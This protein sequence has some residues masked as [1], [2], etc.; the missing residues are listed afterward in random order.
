MKV[1]L[2]STAAIPTPPE[3]YGGI[4]RSAA[5]LT[6]GLMSLGYEVVVFCKTGSQVAS[7]ARFWADD[8]TGFPGLLRDVMKHDSIDVI[9]DMS[10]TKAAAKAFPDFPQ[11]NN[12]QGMAVTWDRNPVFI[13]KGQAS[14]LGRPD[15]PV[16]YHPIDFDEYPVRM[17]NNVG[18]PLLYLGAVIGFKRPHLVAD[19]AQVLE[20]ECYIAGPAWDSSYY[21]EIERIK[22][23]PDVHLLSEVG[24]QEKIEL[25]HRAACLV[26][27]VGGNGWVE[28]GAIAVLEAMCMGIPV[29][30]TPNGC[31]PEYIIQDKTGRLT[32]DDPKSIADAVWA[33]ET[34]LPTTVLANYD[35]ERSMRMAAVRYAGLLSR[36][37][38]GETW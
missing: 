32:A 19:A 37:M 23:L 5:W 26:H 22:A 12:W 2:I 31:L 4:E 35:Y 38:V 3:K 15:A 16:V 28:A 14:F 33:A 25:M 17:V 7:S 27:P 13:S 36:A 1:A 18:G 34:L 20:R 6:K 11:V 24:G 8:E 21:P 30:G 29:V 10:H 9:L